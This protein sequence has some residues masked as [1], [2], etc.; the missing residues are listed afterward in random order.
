MLEQLKESTKDR[1]GFKEFSC[2]MCQQMVS[3]W[4]YNSFA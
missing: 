3:Q 1:N 2:V 4:E